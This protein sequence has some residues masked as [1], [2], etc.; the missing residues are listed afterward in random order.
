MKWPS[1]RPEALQRQVS[2]SV[3]G[4]IRMNVLCIPILLR[5]SAPNYGCFRFLFGNS[6]KAFHIR[7]YK[8]TRPQI[9][10]W[11]IVECH[12]PGSPQAS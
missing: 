11:K 12:G 3:R 8:K 4:E 5:I 6:R 2:P 1:S 10:V 7:S 9:D